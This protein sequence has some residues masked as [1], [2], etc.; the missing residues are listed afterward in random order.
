M[1]YIYL[2]LAFVINA[3]ASILLKLD[4]AGA[5]LSFERGLSATIFEHKL[6]MLGLISFAANVIFYW[7]ALKSL[8]LSVAYPTMVGGSFIIVLGYAAFALHEGVSLTQITGYVLIFVGILLVL[9]KGAN[10]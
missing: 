10:S 3:L 2:L 6:L 1:A 4:A 8:P 9:L 5:P 7:L